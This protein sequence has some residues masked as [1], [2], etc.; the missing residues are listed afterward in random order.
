MLQGIV[1]MLYCVLI[2]ILDPSRLVDLHGNMV[3]FF[4]TA[5][6]NQYTFPFRYAVSILLLDIVL[7]TLSASSIDAWSI[8][9]SINPLDDV[10]SWWSV[11]SCWWCRDDLFLSPSTD[12]YSCT[13]TTFFLLTTSCRPS[14]VYISLASFLI[15]CSC[16]YRFDPL[17]CVMLMRV[18][19]SQN[20]FSSP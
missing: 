2:W 8:N 14:L 9:Q 18:L 4:F 7:L 6:P 1:D 17:L 16:R 12:C 5:L 11:S 3:W 20:G 13:N 10:D 19:V 15:A